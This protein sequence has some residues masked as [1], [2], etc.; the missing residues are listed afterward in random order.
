MVISLFLK[1]LLPNYFSLFF[2]PAS[3]CN[4]NPFVKGKKT[5]RVTNYRQ[6]FCITL[7]EFKR[8]IIYYPWYSHLDMKGEIWRQSLNLAR[9]QQF[10]RFVKEKT[11]TRL[12]ITK[13]QVRR[14]HS[15]NLAY[16]HWYKL[17]KHVV[18]IKVKLCG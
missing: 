6:I 14:D 15:W 5:K 1:N 4:K 16:M 9:N 3:E 13:S 2:F 12:V 17:A 8:L 11:S 7:S 10:C 18:F